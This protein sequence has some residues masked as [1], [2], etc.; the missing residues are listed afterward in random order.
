MTSHKKTT[1][2]KQNFT[3]RQFIKSTAAGAAAI[4]WI[5]S[6][7][8]GADAPGNDMKSR[9]VS[10]RHARM[11][12]PNERINAGIARQ[13]IDEALLLLTKKKNM[14]EAWLQIFPNLKE[15]DTIGLK[16][17]CVNR[18]CPTHPE[19]AYG[20]ADSMID[21]LAMDPNNII[22]WDRTSS[23]LK[24]SGYTINESDKGIRCFGTV[25]RFS[26]G[27]W[28]INRKQDES[29]GIGYDRSRPIDVGNGKTSH[30]SKILTRMCTYL[31]NV[32]V[33]KDHG[34]AGITLSL[35]N[36]YGTIDNPMD[37]HPNHCDPFTA[38]INA[39]SQIKDKTRLIICDAA[40]GIYKGGP[41][42]SPQ[43]KHNSILA[44][45]DPVALDY[46]GM[47]IINAKRKQN[48][49]DL[50][51]DM[52]VHVKSAQTL[53]LGTCN[54]GNIQVKESILI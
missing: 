13:S 44:S 38:K 1:R 41:L 25:D 11:I 4:Y 21:S 53:G 5:P 50:V 7:A 31:V 2:D 36:H 40:Y 19:I 27:R 23:E 24:K 15:Q 18:K 49:L 3:R 37:C 17:N 48:D 28:L 14:K 47:Q 6:L 8:L 39:A 45:T 43:W 10:V 16:V 30:L 9:V 46:T 22:I 51:T 32:P 12:N 33:L 26:L 54:P 52:A 35:K 34:K 42:G 20:I 29:D